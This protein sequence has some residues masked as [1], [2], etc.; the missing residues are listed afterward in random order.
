MSEEINKENTQNK[1]EQE[2]AEFKETLSA[3]EKTREEYLDGWKR[4]KA[5]LTNYKKEEQE[6][7]L[8]II[9]MSRESVILEIIFAL[10]SFDLGLM[11]WKGDSEEKKGM[12]MVR[13][14][15]EDTLKKFGL[16]RVKVSPHDQFNP[17]LHECIAIIE[18]ETESGKI[19][20]EVGNGYILNG[21]VVRPARVKVAK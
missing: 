4:A 14:Q 21:K 17:A 12:T 19:L 5:D 13:F 11:S 9:R 7:T 2:I 20:E 15:L 18:G 6:R 1:T 10:D 16:E 3:C 8:E